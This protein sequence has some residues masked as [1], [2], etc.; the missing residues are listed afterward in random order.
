MNDF[1]VEDFPYQF[2]YPGPEYLTVEQC[3]KVMHWLVT[4]FEERWDFKLDRVYLTNRQ[5]AFMFKLRW[6]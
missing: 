6:V 3:D 1:M 4:N 5:D 2:Y